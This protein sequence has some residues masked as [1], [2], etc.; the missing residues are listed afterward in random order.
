MKSK[1]S[2][3][4]SISDARADVAAAFTKALIVPKALLACS[5]ALNAALS[6]DTSALMKMALAP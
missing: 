2:L 4:V 3:V 1:F 6:S 5:T